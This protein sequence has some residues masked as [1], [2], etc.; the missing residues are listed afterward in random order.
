MFFFEGTSGSR[1]SGNPRFRK[2]VFTATGLKLDVFLFFWNSRANSVTVLNFCLEVFLFYFSEIVVVFLKLFGKIR[3][4]FC[5]LTLFSIVWGP[6]YNL[7]DWKGHGLKS[8]SPKMSLECRIAR[9]LG[10]SFELVWSFGGK[11]NPS[12]YGHHLTKPLFLRLMF[13]YVPHPVLPNNKKQF[14]NKQP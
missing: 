1:D 4:Y 5:D 11:H 13:G 3:W 8:P 12:R 10:D 6:G 9:C 7:F 2:L 14:M